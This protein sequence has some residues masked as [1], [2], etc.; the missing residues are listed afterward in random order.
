MIVCGATQIDKGSVLSKEEALILVY[1]SEAPHRERAAGGEGGI[2][3]EC[4]SKDFNYEDFYYVVVT[5]PRGPST[6]SASVASYAVNK[7]TADV[8]EI[9]V[10]QALN[11]RELSRIQ[12]WMRALHHIDESTRSKYGSVGFYRK[13]S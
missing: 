10:E 8:W 9:G 1:V 4:D 5:D 3:T 2:D 11:D 13:V 6:G 7:R 12:A